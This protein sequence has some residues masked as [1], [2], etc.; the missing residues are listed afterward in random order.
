MLKYHHVAHPTFSGQRLPPQPTPDPSTP[1]SIV[2]INKYSRTAESPFEPGWHGIPALVKPLTHSPTLPLPSSMPAP[3]VIT[4]KSHKRRNKI[5][6]CHMFPSGHYFIEVYEL[7]DSW[8]Q[9]VGTVLPQRDH[10]LKTFRINLTYC[11]V[12]HIIR[13]KT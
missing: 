2:D 3:I 6:H 8:T 5:L 13:G 9:F 1:C 12:Y 4:L 7:A 10:K 11:G